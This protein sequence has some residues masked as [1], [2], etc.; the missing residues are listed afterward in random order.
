MGRLLQFSQ[1]F[2]DDEANSS[3]GNV[4]LGGKVGNK[5]IR[6]GTLWFKF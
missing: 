5:R 2:D 6:K 4:K 3:E 1:N